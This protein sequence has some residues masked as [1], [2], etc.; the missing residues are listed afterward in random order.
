MG[1]IEAFANAAS[2]GAC[3]SP[4][5]MVEPE[6]IEGTGPERLEQGTASLQRA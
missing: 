1:L 4:R 6:A 5:R 3:K 2:C